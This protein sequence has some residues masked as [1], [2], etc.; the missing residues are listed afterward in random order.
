MMKRQAAVKK[1]VKQD[2]LK[3][4]IKMEQRIDAMKAAPGAYRAMSAL[5]GYVRIDECRVSH[6]GTETRRRNR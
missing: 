5:E 6:R 4:A 1:F 2:E 3:G